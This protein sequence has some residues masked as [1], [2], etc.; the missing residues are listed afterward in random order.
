MLTIQHVQKN[1]SRVQPATR[2]KLDSRHI[3]FLIICNRSMH[4][5]FG[6]WDNYSKAVSFRKL[7]PI[8]DI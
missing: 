6:L 4:E 2:A 7:L 5:E 8:D 3:F 1:E